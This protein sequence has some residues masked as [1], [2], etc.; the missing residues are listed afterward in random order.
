MKHLSHYF[1]TMFH[2]LQ[3]S[4]YNKSW[5][6]MLLMALFIFIGLLMFVAQISAPFIYT[7]F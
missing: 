4:Y 3:Y 6:L 5:W 2:V 1:A 7:F